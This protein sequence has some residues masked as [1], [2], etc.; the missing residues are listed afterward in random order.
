[1]DF[2]LIESA[3]KTRPQR[4]FSEFECAYLFEQ[5]NIKF[6]LS[7]KGY[8][9]FPGSKVGLAGFGE[10]KIDSFIRML[11]NMDFRR[12]PEVDIAD[13]LKSFFKRP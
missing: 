5:F 7:Q 9:C 3:L 13:D 10:L 12:N 6:S 11:K 2:H 1:M 4:D 8:L